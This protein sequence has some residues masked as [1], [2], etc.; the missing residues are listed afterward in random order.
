MSYL[1]EEQK[2]VHV[3]VACLRT[4]CEEWER[5]FVRILATTGGI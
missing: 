5:E 1:R 4:L 2:G 3:R